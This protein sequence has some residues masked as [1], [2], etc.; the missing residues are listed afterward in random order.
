MINVDLKPMLKGGISRYS[1]CVAVAKLSR[2]IND[3]AIERKERDKILPEEKPVSLAV[4]K[5]IAGEYEI[6]ESEDI[7]KF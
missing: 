3:E 6:K 5:I 1:L 4:E 2:V 7:K